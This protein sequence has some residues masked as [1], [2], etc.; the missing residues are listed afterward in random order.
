MLRWK[1]AKGLEL[2][3][4][5]EHR[6]REVD[7]VKALRTELEVNLTLDTSLAVLEVTGEEANVA[8]NVRRVRS[9]LKLPC[10]EI[11]FDSQEKKPP[12]DPFNTI[13]AAAVG[14]PFR[15]K[16]DSRGD[17]SAFELPE[18]VKEALAAGGNLSF[19][20]MLGQ[21]FFL[22]PRDA[23]AVGDQWTD[24][25]S[26]PLPGLGMLRY[27]NTYTYEG[28][29]PRDGKA[30]ERIGFKTVVSIKAEEG[31]PFE[32]KLKSQSSKGTI[33]FD[34]EAGHVTEIDFHL[35]M[36]VEILFQGVTREKTTD[37]T[38]KLKLDRAPAGAPPPADA[39]LPADAPPPADDGDRK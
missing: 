17:A 20:E 23:V 33:R 12:E 38:L 2:P 27:D 3:Y 39:P 10:G 31:V 14:N 18:K 21:S 15:Y 34:N 24:T 13:L 1:L 37:T 16:L 26:V 25:L 29:E 7:Q 5:L 36:K 35:E 11:S 8:Q 32:L 4:V 9:R 30:S 19:D 28:T 6:T 22:L